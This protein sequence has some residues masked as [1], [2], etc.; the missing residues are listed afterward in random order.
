MKGIGKVF[1]IDK[2]RTVGS[3]VEIVKREMKKNENIDML[4]K[5]LLQANTIYVPI[6]IL[7]FAIVLWLW[8]SLRKR[9]YISHA[10]DAFPK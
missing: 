4:G 8:R 5:K 9:H 2:N 1:G 10:S 3:V 6:V 7:L